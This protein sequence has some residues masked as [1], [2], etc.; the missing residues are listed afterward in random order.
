[1]LCLIAALGGRF[2]PPAPAGL[3]ALPCC[4]LSRLLARD[5]RCTSALAGG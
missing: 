2:D 3:E 4:S 1:V 5:V